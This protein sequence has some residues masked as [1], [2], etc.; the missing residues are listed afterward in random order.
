MSRFPTNCVAPTMRL[1]S[2]LFALLA[3]LLLA[4]SLSPTYAA[5]TSSGETIPVAPSTWD[6]SEPG[7]IGYTAAG[8]VT[9]NAG[10]WLLSSEGFIGYE[11]GA[12]GAVT[13]SGI[14]S[15]WV[16]GSL[17]VGYSGSGILSIVDGG[18][19]NSTNGSI[20][21]NCNSTGT[22]TVSGT[23]SQWDNS[24]SPLYVGN[25]GS[26]TLKIDSGNV[27]NSDGYVGY[28]SYSTGVA[29]V[30]GT[31]GLNANWHNV[32]SLYVGACGT[33]TL[34]INA[35]GT[36]STIDSTFV[37]LKGGTSSTIALNGGILDTRSLFASPA[38]LTGSG[39]TITTKG[40]VSD[41]ALTFDRNHPLVQTLQL[42]SATVQLDMN[43]VGALGAGW[44][45]A[46]SL[47]IR[48][49]MLVQ[50]LGGYIGYHSTSSGTVT[51]NGEGSSWGTSSDVSGG[52]MYVGCYGTGTLNIT[53]GGSVG[54]SALYDNYIG[55]YPGSVGAV[56]VGAVGGTDSAL[57]ATWTMEGPLYVGG[58]GTG[59]LTVG[60]RDSR[61]TS[62]V[63]ASEIYIGNSGS[64]RLT[65]F[66]THV[67]EEN[68]EYD[69]YSSVSAGN[70]YADM[71]GGS[72]SVI[73]LNGGVLD[74]MNRKG[75]L[76][77]SPAQVTG[78]GGTINT[79]GLV[80]DVNLVFD[81]T[82]DGSRP[83]PGFTNVKVFFS[84]SRAGD[85]GVGWKDAASVTIVNGVSVPFNHGY[86]GYFGN[87][88]ITIDNGGS[89]SGYNESYIGYKSGSTGMVTVGGSGFGSTLAVGGPF[90]AI[91]CS[92]YV[93]Y[94][95][96][97]ILNINSGGSV[98]STA[99]TYVGLSPGSS[100]TITF[101]GGTLSALALAASSSQ[102]VGTGTINVSGLLSDISVVFNASHGLTQTITLDSL[103]NQQISI[104]LGLSA[105]GNSNGFLGAG[106][107]GT[108]S[109]TI[110]DGIAVETKG[111][112]L[113]YHSGSSGEATVRGDGSSWQIENPDNGPDSCPLGNSFYIGKFG[114]GLLTITDGG[115]VSNS[116]SD[117]HIGYGAGSSGIATVG[118]TSSLS[119]WAIGYSLYVGGSGSGTLNVTTGGSVL[120]SEHLY[121]GNSGSGT[122]SIS[123][124]TVSAGVTGT[125]DS[126]VGCL[127]GST[128]AVRVSGT[129]SLWAINGGL[130]VGSAGSGSLFIDNG[131]TVSN[132]Y[133]N[134]GRCDSY[135]GRYD[136]STGSATVTGNGSTWAIGDDS[137]SANL[138]V[139]HFGSGTLTVANGGSVRSTFNSFVGYY[140][141]STGSATVSGNGSTWTTASSL[142]VG[143]AGSG[144]VTQTGGTNTVLGKFYVGCGMTGKGVYNL[145]G[146]TFVCNS[147]G[148]SDD[149]YIGYLPNSAGTVSV[150]GTTS[151]WSVANSLY[152]GY[153]G[154][155]AV[156]Q[157]GGTNTVGGTLSL[158]TGSTGHGTYNLNDGVLGLRGLSGGSGTATFNFGGGTLRADASFTSSLPMTLT[159]T[160]TSDNGKVNTNGNAVTLSGTLSGT[161]GLTKS[162]AGTLTLTGPNSYTGLTVV[163]GD[164]LKLQQA[165]WPA[166]L[167][168]SSTAGTASGGT[169]TDA[170]V[171]IQAGKLVFDYT[172]TTTPAASVLANL[173][174]S[175]KSR[176]GLKPFGYGPMYTS[177]GNA[178]GYGLGWKDNT[179]SKTVTVQVVVWG[180]ADLSGTVG[181]SD[182]SALL[183]GW[184]GTGTNATWAKGDFNYDG[185]VG[186]VDL[187]TLL[188]HWGESL[189]ESYSLDDSG[190]DSISSSLDI[191]RYNIDAEAIS[192]L[193]SHGIQT[194]VP[195]PGSL[196]MLAA[197]I[198][199]ML[200][201]VWRRRK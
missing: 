13:V 180:D 21:N 8:S 136:S 2:I 9:V 171:D 14:D 173:T 200:G 145:S 141:H 176:K 119:T 46:G 90:N 44:N 201:Y 11:G 174:Q 75:T 45:G 124:G 34:T 84:P 183:A 181:S 65:I 184:G 111:G 17:S 123:G 73:E 160:C 161:G 94:S 83:V 198:I 20:G 10:S 172:G 158:G 157:T 147:V 27:W 100:G 40:L 122:M 159:G 105:I 133:S 43:G 61:I 77:V 62:S 29:T 178:A 170:G 197:G 175:Y 81:E 151:T 58:S 154:T 190:F 146:G 57:G 109:L 130:T 92:L 15:R 138:Y 66:G 51:V 121:I 188:A 97:G 86:V 42:G 16:N 112:Y 168:Y 140:P 59:S 128:G 28:G 32:G 41:I 189:P 19:V 199:G 164:R 95:G 35:G 53:G 55:C 113:G 30:G 80:S 7:F 187:S 87:G 185:V 23:A 78:S 76:F 22:V 96:T 152:L 93:G 129:G 31:V 106:W 26:G 148:V 56:T 89:A 195:E 191:S 126:Y 48:D 155:G 114:S 125:Y 88:A 5:I 115:S 25:S 143:Y 149:S 108:G 60:M 150:S 194:V 12:S 127:S 1:M 49:G 156:T 79:A 177:T 120:A 36:V 70:V 74:L 169:V 118:S 116:L 85:L 47:S 192:L 186:S 24:G 68:C 165:A 107:R 166:V 54:S 137:H 6:G 110:E 139:G 163:Q 63:S 69:R 131:G 4:A 99:G 117:S 179:I 64:G 182:L 91:G 37:G 135:I 102:M 167:S 193:N 50:S 132:T 33:G 98:S 71:A 3:V 101:D 103:P 196:T 104:Q 38:Q 142:Y 67:V 82:Y 144:T 52:P 162:G 134:V 72:S 153:G 39:G 18:C